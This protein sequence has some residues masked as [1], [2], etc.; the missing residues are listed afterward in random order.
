MVAELF[1]SAAVHTAS[2]RG[3]LCGMADTAGRRPILPNRVRAL[4]AHLWFTTIV[5]GIV[6]SLNSA[7]RAY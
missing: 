2:E 6:T 3:D 7:Y 4:D 1:V 5:F